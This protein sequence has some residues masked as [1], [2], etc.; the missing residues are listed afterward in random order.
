MVM[1]AIV[2]RTTGNSDVLVLEEI[3]IPELRPKDVLIRVEA[4][5]VC[6]HDVVVRQGI[7]RRKVSMPLVP[8][9]EVAGVIADIGTASSRFQVGDRV[10]TTQ[11]RYVCGQCNDC[12]GGFETTCPD[13]EFMG[14]A[15][16]N[17][18]YAEYVAVDETLI[19]QIPESVSFDDAAIASCAI[20]TE[21]N[22]IRDVGFVRLG[23]RVLITGASGGLGVHGV[24]LAA[25][26]GAQ[27]VAITSS[28]EKAE[29]I[30]QL[31]AHEVLVVARG[32]DF[33]QAVKSVTGGQGVDVVIDNV[34]N[35]VFKPILR[36]VARHARW[37][38]LG[39]LDKQFVPFNPAQL[40]LDHISMLSAISCTRSQLETVLRLMDRGQVKAIVA[41][42]LPLADAARA[43]DMVERNEVN[44]RI[45]LKPN[46]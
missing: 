28:E 17:G 35:A 36:S 6:Y 1:K 22:A 8:G 43:H 26:A 44:G 9:H 27:V 29:F 41:E 40:F 15:H 21:F 4:C 24:Q 33:S 11:R 14:D 37:V 5:G 45:V 10:C 20:G 39:E 32:E 31:G 30:R 23:D 3:P 42:R 46:I 16:L 19:E 12:R 38:M 7:F 18:G 34:G 2:Q 13:L 25:A